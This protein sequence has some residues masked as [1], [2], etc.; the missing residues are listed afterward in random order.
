[1]SNLKRIWV[2]SDH[3]QHFGALRSGP[4]EGLKESYGDE[5]LEVIFVVVAKRKMG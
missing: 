1:M 3:E 2:E 4:V 5:E